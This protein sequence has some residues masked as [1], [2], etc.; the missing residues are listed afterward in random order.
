MKT[1]KNV[2]LKNENNEYVVLNRHERIMVVL[3][4]CIVALPV[5]VMAFVLYKDLHGP[6]LPKEAPVV[7]ELPTES[8]IDVDLTTLSTEKLYSVLYGIIRDSEEHV[9]EVFRIRGI[10]RRSTQTDNGRIY[11]ACVVPNE[12]E[13]YTQGMEFIL[14]PAYNYPDDYP[15]EGQEIVVTGVFKLYLDNGSTY[16]VLAGAMWENAED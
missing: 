5:Y 10:Y 16:A 7:Y 13:A 15:E 4:A 14:G 6:K 2:S 3:L 9:D 12:N 1:D 11:H 8:Q